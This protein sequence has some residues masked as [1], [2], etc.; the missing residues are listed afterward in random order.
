MK[1]VKAKALHCPKDEFLNEKGKS[2]EVFIARKSELLLKK[3]KE[4]ALHYRPYKV[5]HGEK[6]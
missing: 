3:V 1:K 2:K 5:G 4:G 6:R